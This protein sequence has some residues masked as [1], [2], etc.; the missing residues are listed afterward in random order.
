M[1]FVHNP[2]AVLFHPWDEWQYA[3]NCHFKCPFDNAIELISA[4][5]SIVDLY[6]LPPTWNL[7][8]D[9]VLFPLNSPLLLTFQEFVFQTRVA[10]QLPR[11]PLA[12]AAI[13]NVTAALALDQLNTMSLDWAPRE[14][15]LRQQCRSRAGQRR[16]VNSWLLLR[17]STTSTRRRRRWWD[18]HPNT[19]SDWRQCRISRKRHQVSNIS[20]SHL[21]H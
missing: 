13:R 21:S 7:T 10:K 2:W 9:L 14:R 3:I 19:R 4:R 1:Y 5:E 8:L 11:T 6:T 16:R 12:L 17:A 18:Q 20:L 15:T